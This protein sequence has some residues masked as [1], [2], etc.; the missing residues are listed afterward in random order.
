MGHAQHQSHDY[1]R[2]GTAK[3]LTLF[4]PQ[5]GMV[6]VKGVRNCTNAV[7]HPWLQAEL[8]TIIANLPV[9]P[10]VDTSREAWTRWQAGLTIRFSLRDTLP[11]L[12]ILLIFDNLVGHTN[13]AFRCWCMDHG[14]MVLYT[15]LSGSWLNMAES[16]QRVL[17]RR[18]LDGSHPTSPEEAIAWLEAVAAAWNRHPTPFVWSGKRATRRR[19]ARQ[20]RHDVGG[21]GATALYPI[22]R[23]HRNRFDDWRWSGQATH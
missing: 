13:P 5:D 14:I 9:L 6:R 1:Q 10:T 11:P 15:P 23:T 7:L 20:R 18:A 16:I 17:K 19:R 4:R 8:R 12:R 2:C 3:L 21:S 22:T